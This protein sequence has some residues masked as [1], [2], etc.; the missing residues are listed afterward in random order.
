MIELFQLLKDE[1]ASSKAEE[2]P[3]SSNSYQTTLLASFKRIYSVVERYSEDSTSNEGTSCVRNC[4]VEVSSSGIFE[5]RKGEETSTSGRNIEE[6]Y[7]NKEVDVFLKASYEEDDVEVTKPSYKQLFRISAKLVKENDKLRKYNLNL[8]EYLWSIEESNKLFKLE[9]TKIRNSRESCETR[10][11]LEKEVIES[12]ETLGKFIQG[13]EKPDLIISSQSPSLHKNGLGFKKDRKSS[14]GVYHKKNNCPIYKYIHCK[15]VGLLK[16]FCFEKL[17]RFKGYNPRP[18]GK[19]NP[20]GP[21]K[22]WVLEVKP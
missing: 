10:V 21:K 22:I 17:K 9:I 16:P 19:I 2:S 13:K 7:S 20:A 15:R 14:K 5:R 18:Y 8:K 4:E 12:H 3:T 11:S 6:P 1:G